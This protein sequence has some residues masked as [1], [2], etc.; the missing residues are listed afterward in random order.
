MANWFVIMAKIFAAATGEKNMN[1][2]LSGLR[3]PAWAT[4]I[5]GM[6]AC[7]YGFHIGGGMS[8]R[9]LSN[10]GR[11]TTIGNT[12]MAVKTAD[13]TSRLFLAC[14][15]EFGFGIFDCAGS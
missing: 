4:A 1:I 6:P 9:P 14:P 10:T 5:K 7:A 11:A 12:I 15:S 13:E 2:Q 8:V 3:V